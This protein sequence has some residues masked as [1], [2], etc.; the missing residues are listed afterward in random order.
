MIQPIGYFKLWR[1][2]YSKPIWLNSTPVQKVILMTIMAMVNFRPN[3][4][5]WQGQQFEL[6]EGQVITS[7]ENIVKDSGQGVTIR[8]VRTALNRFEKLGFLTNVS[9]KTGRLITIDNWGLYQGNGVEGDKATDKDLTKKRQRPD[10]DLTPK[11]EVKKDKEGKKDIYIK[12]QHLSM[13]KEEYEKLVQAY[14]ENKVKAKLEYA[15]NYKKLKDKLS[16]YLTLNNW[17]K[18][19]SKKEDKPKETTWGWD[20]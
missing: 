7:L 18:S 10:K 20:N 1:E 6:Q 12:C 13:T 17:L 11:E 8:N 15:E 16:L 2:L 14:G 4:W 3:K 19:D 9:T 5:E